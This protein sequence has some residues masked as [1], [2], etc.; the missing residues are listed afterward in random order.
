MKRIIAIPILL[1]YFIAITGAIIN[2]HYCGGRLFSMK[3]NGPVACCCK[4]AAENGATV[5]PGHSSIQ[6]GDGCCSNTVIA[7]KITSQQLHASDYQL[8]AIGTAPAIL[9][10]TYFGPVMEHCPTARPL[11]AHA[12]PGLWQD[13]PLYKLHQRFI[14]YS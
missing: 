4:A 13:I 10:D 14:L 6:T 12:P 8:A 9:P 1:I 2:L 3:V 5:P 7:I 11:V